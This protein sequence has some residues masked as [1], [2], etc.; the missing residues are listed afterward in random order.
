[1]QAGVSDM[2]VQSPNTLRQLDF[3]TANAA[4]VHLVNPR[5]RYQIAA[6]DNVH[7]TGMG[8]AQYGEVEGLAKYT[9]LVEG[10]NWEPLRIVS[11]KVAGSKILLTI[12]APM[13]GFGSPEI[14]VAQIERAPQFGFHVKENGVDIPL[15]SVDFPNPTTIALQLSSSASTASNLEVSYAWYGPGAPFG[16]HVGVWGNIKR[17]GPPSVLFRGKTIDLW[18]C[19][20]VGMIQKS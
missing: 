13:A 14:D 1:M 4:R 5:Y 8:Y 2:T 9:T 10:K 20:Y 6:G 15:K 19:N 18:L 3:A 12:S 17:Q 7:H 11:G 16:T